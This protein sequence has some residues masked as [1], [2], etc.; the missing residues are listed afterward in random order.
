MKHLL[1]SVF[2]VGVVMAIA[3]TIGAANTIN[4]NG[5]DHAI[6]TIVPKHYIGPGTQYAFYNLPT[7]PLKIHVLEVDLNNP[8]IQMETCNGAEK[9][10]G[11]EK[12]TSMWARNDS[13][14]HE[15]VA[16]HNGDFYT[17][18]S[19]EAGMSRMGMFSDSECLFNPVGQPLLVLSGDRNLYTDYVNFTGT[20]TH[21]GNATRIHTL[22]MHQLEFDAADDTDRMILYTN[23]YGSTTNATSGGTK[24][25]VRPKEGTFKFTSKCEYTCIVESVADN[26]GATAIPE[27]S[28]VLYGTGTCA[29]Y[30]Q[31]LAVGDECTIT[32]S[33]ALPSYPDVTD[34]KE[35]MGGSGHF[36]LKDG[37]VV[38]SGNPDIHPRTFMG[39]SKDRKTVYAV[40]VDGRW[41]G[42]EGSAGV[43]LDDEGRILKVLGA[44]DGINLDGGGSTGIVVHG[45]QQNHPS[46]G[47]ERAVGNGVIYFSN[48]PVDDNITSLGF[49]PRAYNVPITARFTPSIYGYN[50]YGVLK[51]RHLDGVTYACDPEVGQI[52]NDTV[53]VASP[54]IAKGYIYATY[55][56]ITEKQFVST[57]MSP[58]TLDCDS[59]IVDNRRG[60]NIQMSAPI[61]NFTY[62]VDAASVD[63]TI[64]DESICSI[65]DGKVTGLI[66]GSTT[67]SGVS[68]NFT[69]K[70]YIKV[71][72]PESVKQAVDTFDVAE[73]WTI[74]Q[75]G[76]KNI[77]MTP[78]GSGMSFTYTGNGSARGAYISVAGNMKTYSLPYGLRIE[79]N[80]GDVLV[81]KVSLTAIT[82][83]KD[84]VTL[85][86]YDDN[87]GLPKNTSTILD[88]NF[89]DYF[90]VDDNTNYPV[91]FSTLR[92]DLG[93]S[94][95]G[96]EFTMNI[97]RLEQLYGDPTGVESVVSSSTS[98]R[99]Y[100]N[101][102]NAGE[103]VTVEAE[104]DAVVEVYNINGSLV[105]TQIIDGVATI[106]T[107]N[108]AS[109]LYIVRV[110][111]TEATAVG[112]LIV[113]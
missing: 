70:V 66:N 18:T 37:E 13:P 62:G 22:N 33:N 67:L 49:E 91:D 20:L 73:E 72:I 21:K 54:N 89:A 63:W 77:V 2:A 61:G 14:G 79:I 76:G 3:P 58:L 7:R 112:K 28:A 103:P 101:P 45:V 97:P 1:R 16:V 10:V 50:Q 15:M 86:F 99:I 52:I 111:S 98:L 48:A 5:S 26:T 104:G 46:D 34:I 44:W 27:N 85:Y 19:G 68:A 87:A 83:N 105:A 107:D 80:P 59:M 78:M 38:I 30:L 53:F 56:G 95:S 106:A 100:P 110:T 74:K 65:E 6:D 4:I 47:I 88:V 84:R 51:T 8:Y 82:R 25:V 29:T 92:F 17:T 108:F 24:V 43:T 75:S 96:T 31:A 64:A 57:V 60:Y 71:E 55:N 35:A 12:P 32:I 81:K 93:A 36:I 42:S 109:G 69:G 9:A 23:R 102:V 94:A 113:K 39:I 40:C 90:D 11:T 41:N